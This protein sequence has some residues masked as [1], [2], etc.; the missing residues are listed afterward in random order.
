MVKKVLDLIKFVT[1]DIWSIRLSDVTSPSKVLIYRYTRVLVLSVRKFIE[2]KLQFRAS[3]LT[4]FSMLSVVP[5][6]ALGFGIAKGF[7]YQ[8]YLKTELAN[9]LKGHEEVVKYL[10]DFTDSFLEKTQ[11]GLI[12]GVGV[13]ILFWTV[14]K[15]FGNIESAFNDIWG[16][17]KSRIFVRKFSDYL[18][19]ML[20]S[21]LLIIT[22]SSTNVFI[23]TQLNTMAKRVELLGYV[24]S[25][26]F[27]LL[28]FAPY[29][30]IWVLFSLLY[31]IMPNTKVNVKSGIIAGIIA[32]SIFQITQWAY[33]HFQIG[34]SSYGAIYGSFAALPLFLMWMQIS[35]L[36][37]LYG[38]EISYADHNIDLYEFETETV[39]I[40]PYAKRIIGLLIAHRIIV[41]FKNCEQPITS[42]ELSKQLKIPIRLVKNTLTDLIKVSIISEVIVPRPKLAAYQPALNIDCLTVKYVIDKL[43]KQGHSSIIDTSSEKTQRLLEIHN[44]FTTTVDKLPEN[45]LLKDL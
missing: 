33:I 2:D 6:L 18:S 1:N 28:K 26:I 38:A 15:V 22:A 13:G 35:W 5:V 34:V 27:F 17:K 32:G 7:G 43:D 44:V 8:E 39:Q 9:N 29:V 25:V 11:G 10:I 4:F 3:A 23:S 12:A 19:M 14:M 41:N 42:M 16:I 24:S 36:I 30:I 21:P 45:V 31:I 37:V 20:V 40:S